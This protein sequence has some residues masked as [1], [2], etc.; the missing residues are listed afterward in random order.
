MNREISEG[1]EKELNRAFV[2]ELHGTYISQMVYSL[3]ERKISIEACTVGWF[4][5]EDLTDFPKMLSQTWDMVFIK[6]SSVIILIS[7][8]H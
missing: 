2:L 3:R 5:Q 4:V 1:R 7:P 8:N 6:H